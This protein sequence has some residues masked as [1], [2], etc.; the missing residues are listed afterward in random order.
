MGKSARYEAPESVSGA[1]R[2][3][4]EYGD[5]VA[6]VAGGTDIVPKINYYELSPGIVM[7]IGRL[8]LGY[9]RQNNGTLVIGA[10]TSMA[11]LSVSEL[12]GAKAS[13]LA[14]AAAS[15]G[16]PA[17]RT[18]ATVGG[19]LVNASPSADTAT[20]LLAM[21]A[22]LKLVSEAG[23][24]AVPLADFFVGP[25]ETVLREN[26]LLT[27]LTVPVA[28]GKTVFAKLGRRK[29][30]T[31]SVVNLAVRL[32]MD[33]NKCLDARIALGSMAPTPLRCL[34]AEALIKGRN[35]DNEAIKACSA[36]AI[37]ESSPID[38]E[39]ASAWYR[40]QAGAAVLARAL[41]E[42]SGQA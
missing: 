31:C 11:K 17:V 32:E 12:I 13:A 20:P 40:K 25:G 35:I 18:A 42:A 6:V 24:R 27:E 16:S 3:L 28:K 39:R 36:A 41:K 14:A 33:G 2:L 37:D 26:E 19:N 9:I 30:M 21:D 7:S 34:K 1:L 10:G 15:L 38:D 23:E 4:A 22:E 8:G 5:Q 29:G